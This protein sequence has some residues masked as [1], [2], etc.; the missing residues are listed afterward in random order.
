MKNQL[1]KLF[2]GSTCLLWCFVIACAP[3]KKKP[4]FSSDNSSGI[5]ADEVPSNGLERTELSEKDVSRIARRHISLKKRSWGEIQTVELRGSKY[6]VEFET[7]EKE[8]RLIG[9]RTLLVDKYSGVVT[10][11]KRR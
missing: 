3:Q 8:Q 9:P 5:V 4:V 10:V 1:N 2:I 6:H 11:K 7:P